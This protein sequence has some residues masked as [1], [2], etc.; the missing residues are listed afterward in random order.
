[1][2]HLEA[3]EGIRQGLSDD[4]LMAR[5]PDAV[6]DAVSDSGEWVGMAREALATLRVVKDQPEAIP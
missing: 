3:A 1:M 6:H 4:E 2:A 5:L